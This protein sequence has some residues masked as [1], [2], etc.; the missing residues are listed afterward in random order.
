[1][2]NKFGAILIGLAGAVGAANAEAAHYAWEGTIQPVR[3]SEVWDPFQ[4]GGELP[5]RLEVDVDPEAVN[6]F[7]TTGNGPQNPAAFTVADARLSIAN[8]AIAFGPRREPLGTTGT[9]A[10]INRWDEE[11]DRLIFTGFF[12]R[13][14]ATTVINFYA[15]LPRDTHVFPSLPRR[16]P[17]FGSVA[18]VEVDRSIPSERWPY[19]TTVSAG[20]VVLAIP[21]P[22]GASLAL[23]A[24]ALLGHPPRR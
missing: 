14:D 8:E 20:Q 5:F 13:G 23:S 18:A 7:V 4:L 11:T 16:P 12:T 3:D 2:P 21:E 24:I 10:Y 17:V 19:L 15:R 1:M 9:L 6:R 22:V